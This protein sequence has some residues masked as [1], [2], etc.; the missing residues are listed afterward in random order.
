MFHM[1]LSLSNVDTPRSAGGVLHVPPS[2]G[3]T[4]WVSGD[5]YTIK[6]TRHDTNGAFAFID[7]IVPPG[8]GPIAHAHPDQDEAFFLLDGELE[9]LDGD[10]TFVAEQGS[11]LFIP[12]GSRHRFKNISGTDVRTLFMFTPG[13]PEELFVESV[14]NL[15]GFT[16][17][18]DR[19]AAARKPV[20]VLKVGQSDRGKRAALGHTGAIAGDGRVF[21]ELLRRH[22]AIEVRELDELVELRE[23]ML[24][25]RLK[26][27]NAGQVCVSPSRFFVHQRIYDR[28][29]VAFSG[30]KDSIG[31]LLTLLDAGIS[32][33]RI[34]CYHH[35]VDGDGPG[36]MD[37]PCTTSY[38]RAVTDALGVPL[39]LS[40]REGG[41]LRE[42]LRDGVPTAPIR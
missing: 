1:S 21:S 27:R 5:I 12:R 34:D 14:R 36:F 11:F 6:A 25:A 26:I 15:D 7:A 29:V 41:F 42:M 39:Y 10:R 2:E 28:F 35:D 16:Q 38:C 20:V 17:A 33:N 40:W 18:L 37:W 31:S 23:A 4:K 32:P 9:F 22:R 30:G 24:L 19:A 8:G 3:L 13:G